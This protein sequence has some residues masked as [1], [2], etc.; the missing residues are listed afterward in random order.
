[1]PQEPL[2]VHILYRAQPGK[3][4]AGVEALEA[5]VSTV[6]EKEPDCLG[7][8]VHRDV[9]DPDRI[10]LFELWT[11]RAAYL[12]PHLQTPHLRAFLEGAAALFAGP[13]EISFWENRADLRRL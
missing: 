11:S 8:S 6:V 12:G 2:T 1:M 7:I 9:A 4:D 13:P 10:L 3:G 5:L